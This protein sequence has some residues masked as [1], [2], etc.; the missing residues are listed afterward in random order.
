MLESLVFRA[1]SISE[2][3]GAFLCYERWQRLRGLADEQALK[4]AEITAC[5]MGM[6]ARSEANRV[7]PRIWIRKNIAQTYG[8]VRAGEASLSVAVQAVSGGDSEPRSVSDQQDKTFLCLPES[9]VASISSHLHA[10]PKRSLTELLWNVFA[11]TFPSPT[12]WEILI[13]QCWEN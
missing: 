1:E 6:G 3:S 2:A 9:G 10:A 11:G 13:M 7:K 12:K 4:P 5:K 8:K